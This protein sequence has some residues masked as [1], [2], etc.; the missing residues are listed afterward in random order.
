MRKRFSEVGDKPDCESG[1]CNER[2]SHNPEQRS[3]YCS[4]RATTSTRDANP[5]VW[6]KSFQAC[7]GITSQRMGT[8][9]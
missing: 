2:G 1:G 3:Q 6:L 8:G 9:T 5:I 7:E 4:S